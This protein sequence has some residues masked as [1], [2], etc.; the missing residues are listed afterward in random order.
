MNGLLS[1]LHWK[2]APP[3]LDLNLIVGVR[4]WVLAGGL[5]VIFVSGGAATSGGGAGRTGGAGGGGGGGGGGAED[6][7]NVWSPPGVAPPALLAT[8]WKW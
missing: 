5:P 4:S 3:T 8:N 1:T 2:L 6:V 7:V